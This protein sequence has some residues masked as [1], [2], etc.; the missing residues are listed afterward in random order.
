[1]NSIIQNNL[2]KYGVKFF[3]FLS[4]HEFIGTMLLLPF[5]GYIIVA[6]DPMLSPENIADEK[7][8]LAW[9]GRWFMLILLGTLVEIISLLMVGLVLSAVLLVLTYGYLYVFPLVVLFGAL[10]FGRKLYVNYNNKEK[11][12]ND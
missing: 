10:Y 8:P 9:A 3:D 11:K 4:E 7:N 6:L 1:M 2:K 12:G 5:W